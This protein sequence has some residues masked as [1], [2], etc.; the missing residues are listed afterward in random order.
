M[1]KVPQDIKLHGATALF[2]FHN[3]FPFFFV[4]CRPTGAS[5]Y[6]K[7][8]PSSKGPGGIFSGNGR[9]RGGGGAGGGGRSFKASCNDSPQPNG[10]P[11]L[12]KVQQNVKRAQV[13]ANL[14]AY[15]AHQRV[16]S[17][18]RRVHAAKA[19][20]DVRPPAGFAKIVQRLEKRKQ[21]EQQRD[22]P[23]SAQP[24]SGRTSAS[25]SSAEHIPDGMRPSTA[26][27][28]PAQQ[29]L[30]QT[31]RLADTPDTVWSRETSTIRP[32]SVGE[33]MTP[34]TPALMQTMRLDDA[35]QQDN[36]KATSS[37]G[38]GAGS[39]AAAAAKLAPAPATA[40]SRPQ[41]AAGSAPATA[42]AAAS[43]AA[44]RQ[45]TLWDTGAVGAMLSGAA[46]T[47][48]LVGVANASD[49]SFGQSA[50]GAAQPQKWRD[51]VRRKAVQD[52]PELKMMDFVAGITQ[53]IVW[54][55]ALTDRLVQED[56]SAEC[57]VPF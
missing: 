3:F 25:R 2:A 24:D 42:A 50:A 55:A 37:P 22:R 38:R 53:D 34:A 41:S 49:S 21:Q 40:S 13:A 18:Q 28:S 7:Y 31:V 17:L 47:A 20:V 39:L 14:D 29:L 23:R 6:G 51:L 52:D 36:G 45:P 48:A 46:R 12:S 8:S 19:C 11:T 33:A 35:V 44:V 43:T 10:S 30:M 56:S 4:V 27:G 16:A 57:T 1:L 26:L 9:G 15:E 32:E 54:Q 5:P